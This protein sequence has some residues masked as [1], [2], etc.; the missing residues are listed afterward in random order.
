M[1]PGN[2]P[3][4][5]DWLEDFVALADTGSFSRAA[6]VR[7]I[8]QPAFSRHIRSLEE[9]A[10]VELC[11]RSAHPVALTAAGQR[12]LPLLR[13]VLAG[14][15]AARQKA[16]AAHES[17]AA[18]LRFAATHVL[19]LTWF[20][21]WLAGLEGRLR[22]GPVQTLSD[23]S[24][25]CEDLALQR[26][27]QFVLCHGHAE[28]AGRLD[29][30][31]H[32]WLRLDGDVL[33]PLSAPDA[34]GRP[35]H[36]LAAGG[37]LPV[38]AYSE[39]SGLGRILRAQLREWFGDEAQAAVEPRASIVFTAHHAILLKAM[40][41]EGKGVAWLPAS[42]VQD[43]LHSG[44]LVDAGDGEWRV[45][46]DIRL[47]RQPAAMSELAESLWRLVSLPGEAAGQ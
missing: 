39:A 11:D 14:L 4:D 10:G 19:S 3:L 12:F 13:G 27:V 47:Y 7:H 46:V 34:Q 18:S 43:E 15:E 40:V 26:R 1:G 23:S 24:L 22:I 29:E 2:R 8:A 41:R 16:R 17:A 9:W 28:V 45:P 25:A 5:L 30:A 42:L 36:D 33:L 21:T 38:L 20:P 31:Q 37:P 32:P 44:A 35:L 6:E